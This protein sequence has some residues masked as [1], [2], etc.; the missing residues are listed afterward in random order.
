MFPVTV[1]LAH[2]ARFALVL[3]LL[4]LGWRVVLTVLGVPPT[5]SDEA[6]MGL[7]A[8]HVAQGNGVPTY[9]YGQHYMGT[10]EAVLAAPLVAVLGPSVIALRVV[11]LLLYAAMLVSV[12]HLVRRVFSPGLAVFTVGLL[13]LGGDRLVLNQLQAIGGYPESVPMVA[14]LLLLTYLLVTRRLT[15]WWAFAGWGLLFGLIVWNHWSPAPYL[16]GALVVLL[17]FRVLTWRTAAVTVGALLVGALPLLIDNVRAEAADRSINVFLALN[18]AGPAAPLGVR[19]RHGGFSGL[20]GALGL[21]E[22]DRC[23]GWAQVWAPVIV[24]LLIVA[25][26]AAIRG[27]R[28]S[29]R[30][31][32]AKHAVRLVLAGAALVSLAT[33][34][35]SPA[36]GGDPMGTSRYLAMLVLSVPAAIWPVWEIARPASAIVVAVRWTTR[37]LIPAVALGTALAVTM[38]FATASLGRHIPRYQAVAARQSALIAALDGAGVNRIHTDYWTCYWIT[39]TTGERIVC[40]VLSDDASKGH[41]RYA[42]YWRDEAQAVVASVGSP[43]AAALA[44]RGVRSEPPLEPMMT[45]AGYVIYVALRTPT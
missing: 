34:L 5:N 8:L 33:Y 40:G 23:A 42:P 9:F 18:A 20:P 14:G 44:E 28:G 19:I 21:C 10:I 24:A 41:N 6:I 1:R 37:A 38:A 39:Y 30:P 29:D 26:V 27:L 45:V 31:E 13:A 15:R 3:G 17:A 16:L 35:N 7:A 36:A 43:L 4:G 22:V 11:T 12:F 32:H 2:P 25:T